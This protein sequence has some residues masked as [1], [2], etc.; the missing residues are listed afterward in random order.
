MSPGLQKVAHRARCDRHVQ[1]NALA[2][3]IDPSQ[4]LKAFRRLQ[5]KA[6]VGVDGVTKHE[7]GEA[8]ESNLHD[9]H[10]RLRA[11]RYRHQPVRRV[12]IPKGPGK[13]RPI[14]IAATEDKVVQT[15]VRDVLEAIYEQDFLDCSFGFRPGRRAHDAL[16]ELRGDLD[17]GRIGWILEA[18]LLD[19]FGSIDRTVL[20][21]FL[22]T[23]IVDRSFLR[24]VGKC[25]HVGVLDGEVYEE[26]E[27]G[28]VQGSTL[29]PMLGNIYLHY[30]LDVWFENVVRPRM[31]GYVRMWRFADD[32]ILGFQHREDA[33]RVLRVLG[34]RLAKFMLRLHP[35]KTRLVDFRRPGR[36]QQDGKG[37]STFDFLGFTFHWR[38]TR[39]GV[40]VPD[41][42]TR[43]ASLHKAQKA[44]ADFCRRQRHKPIRV[45]HAGLVARIRGHFNYFGIQ[46]NYHRLAVL[47]PWARR[48]WFKWLNRRS[49][50][51]SY[52][53]ERFSDLLHDFPLPRPRISIPLWS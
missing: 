19:Y 8:L 41:L 26:P 51:A 22:R 11:G 3:Y 12:H 28:T 44:I 46:G 37:V 21:E 31:R 53:W 29:S 16:R 33:D 6:A 47:N 40:W 5:A 10:Q 42:R 34:K 49:Q 30:A 7:Y 32:F 14:G 27:G 4:L 1:F 20:Q 45:Q 17:Q 48:M 18:D 23:R 9:L 50:R 2:H 36:K 38:R 35:E 52:T 24:L 25:V 39:R 13:T 15:A 43:T